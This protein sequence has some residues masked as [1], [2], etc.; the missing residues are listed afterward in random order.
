MC[1]WGRC[2]GGENDALVDVNAVRVRH[3]PGAVVGPD[4]F[5][6]PLSRCLADPSWLASGLAEEMKRRRR[7][8][9]E[10]GGV[11]SE[12]VAIANVVCQWLSTEAE[13]SRLVCI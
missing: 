1:V 11:L 7:V 6:L 8:R 2:A 12:A 4:P 5:S 13:N 10:S 9:E 3:Y